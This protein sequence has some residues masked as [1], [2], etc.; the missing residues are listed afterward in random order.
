[1]AR[2]RTF[3]TDSGVVKGKIPYLAPEQ[4]QIGP[5]D[6]RVDIYAL[7]TTLWETVTMKR[8]FKR[9]TDVSTL[10]A[11]MEA[12]VPDV[13][14]MIEGFPDALWAI[15][16]KALQRDK[17][18]RFA[19]AE[20]MQKELDAFV[21]DASD[22]PKE[23]ASLLARLFPDLGSQYRQWEREAISVRVPKYTMPPPAPVP[24]ASSTVLEEKPASEPALPR[25]EKIETIEKPEKIEKSEKIEKPEKKRSS[26][27]PPPQKKKKKKKRKKKRAAEAA[28]PIQED[29]RP[30]RVWLWIAIAAAVLIVL[31][32]AASR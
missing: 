9:D 5:I 10:K 27:P 8:L 16:S 15:I 26:R 29:T 17:E 24:T 32:Y 13:R 1:K 30:K 12:E 11:I 14:K 7:G 23:L 20:D 19:T 6:R 4:A 2:V 22:L 25:A 31:A 18:L 3:K 28:A 21:G